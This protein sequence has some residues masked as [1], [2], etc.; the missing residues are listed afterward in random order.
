[1]YKSFVL[2]LKDH[3]TQTC[4]PPGP[5]VMFTLAAVPYRAAGFTLAFPVFGSNPD[6]QFTVT[7]GSAE[8]N[9]PLMRSIT[10]TNP[11]FGACINTL[12][13]LP[14]IVR[15]ASVMSAMES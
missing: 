11:F 13:C 14:L 4:P 15:S 3:G 12:R 8:M 10:N 7:Q 6:V 2:G 9:C 1:M 5:G